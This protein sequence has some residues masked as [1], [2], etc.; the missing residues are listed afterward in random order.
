MGATVVKIEPEMGAV[1]TV[2]G[3]G[4]QSFI[5]RMFAAATTVRT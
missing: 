1:V 3:N 2:R 5:P 4:M